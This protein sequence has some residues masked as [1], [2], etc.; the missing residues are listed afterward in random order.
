MKQKKII[1]NWK[2]NPESSKDADKLFVFVKKHSNFTIVIAPP[3]VYL[4]ELASFSKKS[5]KIKIASQDVFYAPK[6]SYTGEI[7][8]P[9]LK[10][11]GIWG[12]IIG[13]SERRYIFGESDG[14]IS[15]KIKS[16]LDGK[17]S[18]VLCVGERTKMSFNNSWNYVKS[19]LDKD[20]SLIQATS[21][22]LQATKLII[23]YEPVW[24]IGGHKTTDASHSALMI[25]KIKDLLYTRYKIQATTL[26]G[27]SVNCQNI[28]SFLEYPE[29]DGF[30]VG[31]ASLKE[32]EISCIINKVNGNK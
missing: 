25:K 21:Y 9:M 19:Q 7:S 23:A 17:L 5:S 11:M 32:K 8:V 28:S 27:G 12:S 29:I 2:M 1:F 3:S 6:G 30:L 10:K 13:H 20:L 15:K 4:Q 24:S 26:Y 22:K 16:A 31:S 18:V 14:L